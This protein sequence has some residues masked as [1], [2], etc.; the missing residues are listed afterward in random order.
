[1]D[2]TTLSDL[3]QFI[4]ATVSQQTADIKQDIKRLDE[5]IDTK[6]DALDSKLSN[7]IDER[8]EEILAAVG[9][10]TETRFELIEQDISQIKVR[11]TK[12]ETA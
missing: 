10:S 12:L 8:T 6:I 7:K 4:A 5:K 3:K 2:E 9:E 11:L 1:M